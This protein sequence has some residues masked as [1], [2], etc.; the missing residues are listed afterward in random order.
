MAQ[1]TS[2]ESKEA[3]QGKKEGLLDRLKGWFEGLQQKW[4]PLAH[5]MRAVERYQD[6]KA[7][8]FAAGVTYYSVLSLF[9]VIMVGFAIL[10][11]VLIQNPELLEHI[12]ERITSMAQG[13]LAKQLN[14]LIDSAIASRTTVG[15]VGLAL[16][17]W[18]GLGWMAALRESLTQL[19][20]QDPDSEANWFKTKFSDLL[21]MASFG[22]ALVVVF[23]LITLSKS[24]W[25]VKALVKVGLGDWSGGQGFLTIVSTVLA[26]IAA[27]LL[28]TFVIARLPRKSVALADASQAGLLGA[29]LFQ[30][31]LE[32]A[33]LLL[34]G[35]TN[36][37]AGKTF[38]PILGLMVFFF[39]T[40]RIVLFAT[41]W[42]ATEQGAEA[43][44]A[45]LDA[46]A[47]ARVGA[48]TGWLTGALGIADEDE[49]KSDEEPEGSA[50]Q[51]AAQPP[52]KAAKN[53]A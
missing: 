48:A 41:A 37:P 38:G 50:G 9:P 19:W 5:L 8:F 11:Q 34:K 4:P 42:A 45:Q 44:S 31:F 46:A 36:G 1:S 27:W 43:R 20:Q 25:L 49:G 6:R 21:A 18:S 53:E 29:I 47:K 26:T 51:R 13:G 15:T 24:S 40:V 35:V 3:D 30:I 16:G 10:G 7:D 2:P 22:L 28:F 33:W 17:L 23:G 12:K 32:L 52:Q 39:F 14:Q